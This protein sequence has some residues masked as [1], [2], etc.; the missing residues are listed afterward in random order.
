MVLPRIIGTGVLLAIS[1]VFCFGQDSSG[2]KITPKGASWA[3]VGQV[4]NGYDKNAGDISH[5]YFQRIYL[6]PGLDIRLSGRTF[7]S[8]SVGIK[9]FNEFP[10]LIKL[11]GTRRYYYYLYLDEAN[12]LHKIVNE[13]YMQWNVGGGYF[14]Y[15]YNDNARNL[16]EY[17]FRSTAY[18]QTLVNEFD[19]PKA[20][21]AG[22]YSQWA[23]SLGNSKLKLDLLAFTNTEWAAIGDLNIAAVA[24]YNIAKIFEV[25]AG[26]MFGSV[27]SA[28]EA[29]TTPINNATKYIDGKDTSNYYTF[30]GTKVM[31]RVSF[32][33]KKLLPLIDVFGEEDLKIYGEAALLGVKDYGV[34]LRAPV[35]YN[36][37]LE[38]IPVMAGINWPTH[39]F[40]SYCVIPEAMGYL[41]EPKD[42]RKWASA[43][44]S[45]ATGIVCGI[46]SWLMDRWMGTNSKL[47]VISIEGEWWGN[48]YPNSM[49][50][51]V[52]SG[53]PLPFVEGTNKVDS[54]MY[55]KDN[56]K[57]SI[58]AKKTFAKHYY[59]AAQAAS[60]HMRTFAW[61]WNR[62]DWEESLRSP[63][64]WYYVLKF[65]ILF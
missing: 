65:G 8:G 1:A 10:R 58:Y 47:D 45:G 60:D 21:L 55:K 25:G 11:G 50:G 19:F 6:Q 48:R 53:L 29:T 18:P 34:A 28:D 3:E 9:A 41:L 63:D 15:K 20:R 24:S 44:I 62:Q 57:W 30:R 46:G 26:I 52:E 37:I 22:L 33:P 5:V 27:I 4:V 38:R 51:I 17:L 36:S 35:W 7:F 59:L 12:L 2:F 39:Q 32:D 61:D 40:L 16:G 64:K 56:F 54:T 42:T 14:Q 49:Q 13:N 31:G 43:G 23:Y